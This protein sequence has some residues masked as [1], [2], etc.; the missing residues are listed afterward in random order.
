VFFGYT[1]RWTAIRDDITPMRASTVLGD[2]NLPLAGGL[3]L[4]ANLTLAALAWRSPEPVRFSLRR[5]ATRRIIA[6]FALRFVIAFGIGFAVTFV[7]TLACFDWQSELVGAP[8]YHMGI[9]LISGSAGGLAFGLFGGFLVSAADNDMRSVGP[10]DVIRADGWYELVSS[11]VFGSMA[12]AVF[13]FMFILEYVA[14][15][16]FGLSV[17]AGSLLLVGLVI[18]FPT[19]VFAGLAGILRL[20]SGNGSCTWFRYHLA[21]LLYAARRRGPL[22]FGMFL[23][24]AHDAGLLRVSGPAYQF[25]HRQIQDWLTAGTVGGPRRRTYGTLSNRLP[26]RQFPRRPLPGTPTSKSFHSRCS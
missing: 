16:D 1:Y 26:I 23:D 17:V 10:R 20:G 14:A 13:S 15:G 21:V 11:L 2:V 6:R 9:S 7:V 5:L 3:A 22:R 24:W 4:L 8:E 12:A 18:G 25:R 19:G